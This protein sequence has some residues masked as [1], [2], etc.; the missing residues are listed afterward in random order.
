MCVRGSR[1]VPVPRSR[2]RD[3]H[4]RNTR[5]CRR[6]PYTSTVSSSYLP[7]SLFFTLVSRPTL[8]HT[9]S[10]DTDPR[11]IS[12]SGMCLCVC[13]RASRRIRHTEDTRIQAE[14]IK[15]RLP[16]IIR[17]VARR[18]ARTNQAASLFPAPELAFL[19][20]FPLPLSFFSFFL[21]SPFLF[22]FSLFFSF[23]FPPLPSFSLFHDDWRERREERSVNREREEFRARARW[24]WFRL[25]WFGS[26]ARCFHAVCLS[27]CYY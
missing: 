4:R 24:S 23:F 21:R 17:S 2:L 26:S 18:G 6:P 19:F 10:T 27:C 15:R 12:S 22:L 25:N 14:Q 13:A 7:P 11:C 16:G 8:A 3:N 9:G 20:F 5:A 1:C